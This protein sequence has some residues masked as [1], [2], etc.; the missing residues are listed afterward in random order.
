MIVT[1]TTSMKMA[2]EQFGSFGLNALEHKDPLARKEYLKLLEKHIMKFIDENV[3][4]MKSTFEC[5]QIFEIAIEN[6]KCD[7]GSLEHFHLI[8]NILTHCLNN[9]YFVVNNANATSKQQPI[10]NDDDKLIFNHPLRELCWARNEMLM[11]ANGINLC[12]FK[13]A[14]YGVLWTVYERDLGSLLIL[15]F[16]PAND[17]IRKAQCVIDDNFHNISRCLNDKNGCGKFYLSFPTNVQ[18]NIFNDD[19]NKQKIITYLKNRFPPL[20]LNI[21]LV[22]P[23]NVNR[24]PELCISVVK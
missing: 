12:C 8:S 13:C 10:T 4:K 21:C 17:Y 9:N 14:R 6:V 1:Q 11:K 16:D 7:V 5:F 19:F 23:S 2:N 15:H 24:K 3:G 20:E 18:N 22:A